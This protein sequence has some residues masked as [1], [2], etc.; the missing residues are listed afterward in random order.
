M[1][2][3]SILLV[4]AATRSLAATLPRGEPKAQAGYGDPPKSLIALWREEPALRRA[5]MIQGCLF[6]SFTAFWTILALQLSERYHLGAEAAGLFGIA[7]VARIL[8]APIAGKT[9]DRRG[10]TYLIAVG[11]LIMLASWCIFALSATIAG[12]ILG[13]I[14]LDFGEQGALVSNQQVIYAIRPEAGCLL[15][16]IF[17]GGMFAGGAIGS[18]GAVLVWH[19]GRLVRSLR[20]RG[21][22]GRHRLCSY[23]A[24]RT[25]GP[26]LSRE[27]CS[28]SGT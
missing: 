2:W 3:L 1:Y 17:M 9:G 10:P 7:G 25:K 28:L 26:C 14:V 4:I 27:K 22:F 12:L 5:T 6:G 18:A 13:V 8:F 21:C 16:T 23:G 11:T 19:M 15:N 20:S 24:P